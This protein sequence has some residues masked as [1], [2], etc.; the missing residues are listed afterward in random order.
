M[1]PPSPGDRKLMLLR[2]H[3]VLPHASCCASTPV[4]VIHWREWEPTEHETRLT[5]WLLM[6]SFEKWNAPRQPKCT[7][8]IWV[9]KVKNLEERYGR[10]GATKLFFLY[11]Y[12]K[13]SYT[14]GFENTGIKRVARGSKTYTKSRDTI[15]IKNHKLNPT[16]RTPE[17]QT[18]VTQTKTIIIYGITQRQT[19]WHPCLKIKEIMLISWMQIE[20]ASQTFN[21]HISIIVQQETW[22]LTCN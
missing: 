7:H 9:R 3:R 18:V 16:A 13:G 14:S 12:M 6:F 10:Y 8:T 15:V 20:I 21:M 5:V 1:L 4:T 19:L 17:P 22:I 2:R 11:I